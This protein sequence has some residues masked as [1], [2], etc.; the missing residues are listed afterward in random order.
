V[1]GDLNQRSAGYRESGAFL[2]GTIGRN[3]CRRVTDHVP[4]DDLDPLALRS[5]A[6]HVRSSA[7][8]ELWKICEAT[9]LQ[10]VADVHTHP[11]PV[12]T[13]SPID[14][15]HPMVSNVGH[16]AII[17]P[18]FGKSPEDPRQAGVYRYRGSHQWQTLQDGERGRVFYVGR[19]A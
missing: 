17:L 15:R 12:V 11:G 3:G 6:I 8:Y 13:Q 7:Y 19:W 16:V 5:G 9:G 2:L 4:Y 10:V 14:A 1:V 18:N